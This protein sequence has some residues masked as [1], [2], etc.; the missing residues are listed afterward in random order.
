MSR[1]F[2]FTQC[3]TLLGTN[4]K[5]FKRWLEEDGIAQQ[6]NRADARE[7]YLTEEQ[8]VAMARKRDIPLQL[9]DPERKPESTSGKILAGMDSR[10]TTLE[11][12]MTG[13]FDQ[14]DTHLQTLEEIRHTLEQL[15]AEVQ[16][17][18][19]P[20]PPQEHPPAPAPHASNTAPAIS[21][22]TP[23]T[24]TTKPPQLTRQVRRKRKKTK[25]RKP[26]PSTYVPLASFRQLH[27]V[28][29]KAVEIAT[30]KNILAVKRGE[31][32]HE[33]HPIGNALDRPGQQQ[34]YTLFHEREK[35]QRCDSCPH[36]V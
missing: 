7:K 2:N 28:T 36:A 8:L 23:R 9:P 11:Q 35:F 25:A 16:R 29:E 18:R 19:A 34:F 26:L 32:V 22:S 6:Q 21:T 30:Q 10:I 4:F 33:H 12:Q 15:M 14:V 20:A 31:W 5:T 24:T 3:V 17:L 13:R 27:N 1:R